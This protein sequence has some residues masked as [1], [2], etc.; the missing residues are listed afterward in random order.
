MPQ[1]LALQLE[2]HLSQ[3]I[4]LTTSIKRY[5]WAALLSVS[6]VHAFLKHSTLCCRAKSFHTECV[7]LWKHLEFEGIKGAKYAATKPPYPES[8]NKNYN[9]ESD[10]YSCIHYL[11]PSNRNIMELIM[12]SMFAW[13]CRWDKTW[14]M[15]LLF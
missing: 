14:S 8:R 6:A 5:I 1:M 13:C 3:N 10:F 12:Q 7:S 4:L 15:E 11:I 2:L 9:Y